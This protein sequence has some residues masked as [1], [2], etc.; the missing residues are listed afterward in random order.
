[1]EIKDRELHRI[2]I[3]AIIYNDKGQYLVTKRSPTKKA[4]PNKWT[5]PGGGLEVDDY[6]N[7]EPTNS[8][9]QWYGAL[10]KTLRRE[11]K[12]EVNV[13][14][15]KPVYLMDLTFIRPDNIPVLVL[16]YY[17]K[18]LSGEVKL[19]DDAV[20]YKWATLA[21]AKELDMIDG[22]WEEIDLVEKILNEK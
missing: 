5:V 13:E 9:N 17:A 20:D 14:I 8:A 6:I 2:A 16:S 10:E 11:I 18:Y 22:I 21:E 3:T 4:F 15:D 7:D 19:D 12:E 1:M